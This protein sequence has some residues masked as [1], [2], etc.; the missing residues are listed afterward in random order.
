MMWTL[1]NLRLGS[2]H[3][4]TENEAKEAIEFYHMF[5]N[6]DGNYQNTRGDFYMWINERRS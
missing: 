4:L 5:K 3:E 2:F 6:H 1:Y